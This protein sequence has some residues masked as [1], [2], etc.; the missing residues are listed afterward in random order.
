MLIK[1]AEFHNLVQGGM[2]VV[3][4]IHNFNELAQYAPNEVAT[5]AA[6]NVRYELGLSPVMQ[7]RIC[8]VST[9]CWYKLTYT[10]KS[11]SAQIPL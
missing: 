3:E 6:K 11:A 1:A 2:L 5:D 9:P 10:N 4:Y 7:D 8:N